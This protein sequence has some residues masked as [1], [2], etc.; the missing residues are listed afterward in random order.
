MFKHTLRRLRPAYLR[1]LPII[2]W[3]DGE[4]WYVSWHVRQRDIVAQSNIFNIDEHLQAETDDARMTVNSS[5]ND[6][7]TTQV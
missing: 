1:N 2:N 4:H 3:R 5:T 6:R 7:D